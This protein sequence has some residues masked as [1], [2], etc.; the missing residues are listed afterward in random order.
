MI[1]NKQVIL[2][3][4]MLS[5]LSGG[6]YGTGESS[7]LPVQS[8]FLSTVRAARKEVT[9]IIQPNGRVIRPG[10]YQG[11]FSGAFVRVSDMVVPV[12][13]SATKQFQRFRIQNDTCIAVPN[14][15]CGG[16]RDATQQDVRAIVPAEQAAITGLEALHITRQQSVANAARN[17]QSEQQMVSLAP[18]DPQSLALATGSDVKNDETADRMQIEK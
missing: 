17:Q 10:V 4:G 14:T 16:P 18:A 15:V 3:F 13:R 11:T 6:L 12:I 2:L 9:A 1:K 7:C 5:V 8:N